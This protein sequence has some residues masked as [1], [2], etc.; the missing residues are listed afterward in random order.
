MRVGV[1]A[2]LIYYRPAGISRYTW[3][4]L[5][6]LAKIDQ[7]DDFF[8]F[9]HRNHREPIVEQDN[10]RRATLFA[11][12]HGKL[13]QFMLPMELGRFSLDLIH[14]TDFIPPL[15]SSIPSVITV[16]DLAFLHWPHLVTQDSAQY[17]GQ[18]D[19]AVQH[20][21]QIIVPSRS[22][23]D[24]AIA[25]FGVPDSKINVI[26]EAADPI[27]RPLPIEPARKAVTARHRIPDKYIFFV[28]TI[29]PRKNVGGLLRSFR[30]LLDRYNVQDTALVLAGSEGWLYEDTMA[31]VAELGLENH[32]RFL[33]RV[34]DPD[35]LELYVGAQCHIHPAL[36]EGF[37]LPPLEAMACGTP[38]IV[39]N[40]SS[41][42]E[43]V[44]DAA[45]LVNPVDYEEIAV[46]MN[47]LLTDEE[48]HAELRRKGLSQAK[49]FSWDKAASA[50]LDVYRKV[51]EPESEQAD[52]PESIRTSG[53]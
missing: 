31:L 28:S 53:P 36:Y 39:S 22:T 21:Q 35:L 29:E 10:F 46:A 45:L 1:D 49:S 19:R 13:E 24:D 11:P 15:R 50:T 6:A 27:F 18:I 37:G 7:C 9:Q 34:S 51:V 44:N 5:R 42:P 3:H 33:G 52:A 16:H 12:A 2:R 41:L 26:A 43:V 48:L 14:S 23:R 4:L 40:V 8:V 17:Y 47:R 30:I 20:V 38:T 25:L 32:T